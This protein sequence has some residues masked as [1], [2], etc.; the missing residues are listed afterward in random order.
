MI[1][2]LNQFKTGSC[3]RQP[4]A[5]V[6]LMEWGAQ[7]RLYRPEAPVGFPCTHE[8]SMVADEA[9]YA[10]GSANMTDNSLNNSV[11]SCMVTRAADTGRKA[12]TRFEK[13]WELAR[14]LGHEE[15]AQAVQQRE[16]RRQGATARSKSTEREDV[17]R[18]SS[19]D[20]GRSH[21]AGR[22]SSIPRGAPILSILPQGQS[23]G[24]R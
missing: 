10:L 3:S 6:T 5:V 12:V 20:R 13:L 4:A 1:F 22:A 8:K 24:Q 7:I 16:N 18:Q 11:E 2:D 15:A 9:I 17:A 21:R 14:P 23:Q 19:P